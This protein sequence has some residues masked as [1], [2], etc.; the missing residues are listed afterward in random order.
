MSLGLFLTFIAIVV[1]GY[2]ILNQVQRASL[3][4]FFPWKMFILGMFISFILALL[5]Y[6]ETVYEWN[7]SPGWKAASELAAFIIPIGVLVW[8]FLKCSQA[9]LALKRKDK[10]SD[11][12]KV[13]L[14]ENL[15]DEFNRITQKNQNCIY[16]FPQEIIQVMFNPKLVRSLFQSHSWLPLQLLADIEFIE[17]V[18][19][20]RLNIV[21]IVVR[22]ML[23]LQESPLKSA[24]FHKFGGE[25]FPYIFSDSENELIE[26]TFQ[27]PDW[28]LKTNAHYPL[29]TYAWEEIHSGKLDEMYNNRGRLYET[30]QGVSLRSNCIIF[31][32]LKTHV[33]AIQNAIE[34]KRSEDFYI[35]NLFDIFRAVREHSKYNPLVWE[36]KTVNFEYP[37]P[38]AFLLHEIVWDFQEL[39]TRCINVAF[40]RS[41]NIIG[42]PRRIAENLAMSWSFCIWD[43]T[44]SH[45][46]VSESFRNCIIENYLNFVLQVGFGPSEI[47]GPQASQISLNDWRNIYVNQIKERFRG[48]RANVTDILK[49]VIGGLDSG[50]QY[51]QQGRGWLLTEMDLG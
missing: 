30:S 33:I 26:N 9:R 31:L 47:L 20:I 3:S 28:Y 40:D 50:K 8:G 23:I 25:Q 11:F 48:E 27:N 17:K 6:F 14:R 18:D 42:A 4:I 32:S 49:N 29:V 36:D 24:I 12:L 22:E 44:R 45:D 21:N 46:N 51:V 15:F 39:S 41:N 2:G 7:I 13:C 1:A 37:T 16:K 34:G 10:F 43:I 19:N 35:S 38:F 5:P